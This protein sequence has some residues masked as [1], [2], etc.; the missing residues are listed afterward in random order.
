[1]SMNRGMQP[2]VIGSPTATLTGQSPT[3]SLT[4][5]A[6]LPSPIGRTRVSQSKAALKKIGHRDDGQAA[7]TLKQ[8]FMA[9][10]ESG[11]G[12]LEIEELA[13]LLP[14]M[15]PEELEILFDHIDVDG[16]HA[17][18]FNEFIDFVFGQCSKG[19]KPLAAKAPAA[20]KS[21]VG[22]VG[23]ENL[24]GLRS[25][26]EIQE[27][28]KPEAKG[29]VEEEEDEEEEAEQDDSDK[30]PPVVELTEEEQQIFFISRS[31][32]DLSPQMLNQ[33]FG[34]FSIPAKEEGFDEI[35][36]EWQDEKTSTEYLRK[37]VLERK[38]TSRIEDLQPSEWFKT[39]LAAWKKAV[40]EWKAKQK[41]FLQKKKE[42]PKQKKQKGRLR[43]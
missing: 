30:E 11:N 27:E 24:Q 8:R 18:S 39:K 19:G 14:T 13:K 21:V 43:R 1:M 23:F 34:D 15:K 17:V 36:F 35:R 22:D 32:P 10:D 37:W 12:M 33:S 2:T 31:T 26:A 4:P 29:E 9:L 28:E 38:V 42:Q 3:A 41:P 6:S 16:N 20:R 40:E 5:T 7:A 25:I